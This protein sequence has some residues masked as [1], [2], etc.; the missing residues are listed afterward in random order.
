MARQQAKLEQFVRK[1]VEES[2]EEILKLSVEAFKEVNKHVTQVDLEQ[3]CKLNCI[4]SDIA[5]LEKQITV[6][7]DALDQSLN[8][9]SNCESKLEG[10]TKKW[11][12]TE[13]VNFGHLVKD[14][15]RKQNIAVHG[16]EIPKRIN[17]KCF[18]TTFLEKWL[19]IKV[20]IKTVLARRNKLSG[21]QF[22]VIKLK[23]QQ[24]KALVFKNC[25]KLKGCG[26]K[27][28][29]KDDLNWEER[30]IKHDQITMIRRLKGQ[31]EVHMPQKN[32]MKFPKAM[33]D[34]SGIHEP[35]KEN[36]SQ[37]ETSQNNFHTDEQNVVPCNEEI[38]GAKQVLVTKPDDL[39]SDLFHTQ[40]NAFANDKDVKKICLDLRSLFSSKENS[41]RYFGMLARIAA[42]KRKQ[43]TRFCTCK[44]KFDDLKCTEELCGSIKIPGLDGNEERWTLNRLK[45]GRHLLM[46][47][48]YSSYWTEETCYCTSFNLEEK[49][50]SIRG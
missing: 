13:K 16:L 49:I 7:R 36:N 41:S 6:L 24:Q 35:D 9:I 19:E 33:L 3:K 38:P 29:I 47:I 10:I 23:S 21:Y 1:E 39:D 4:H 26:L 8:R 31:T 34:D 20:D 12:A 37:A 28:S 22:Y 15:E 48:W 27:I 42:N 25:H 17:W 30:C 11:K 50:I 44:K 32:G 5:A 2:R 40:L 45:D 46:R 18:I 43:G 14:C